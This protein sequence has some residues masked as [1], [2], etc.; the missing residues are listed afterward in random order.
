MSR[1]DLRRHVPRWTG[2]GFG[3]LPSAVAAVVLI[4]LSWTAAVTGQQPSI[5]VEADAAVDRARS[6]RDPAELEAARAD[7]LELSRRYP[8]D[9]YPRF[10]GRSRALVEAASIGRRLGVGNTAAGELLQVLEREPASQWTARAHLE[11][12]DLVLTNGDWQLAADH[13]WHARQGALREAAGSAQESGAVDVPRLALERMTRIDRL[14]LR[15]LAGKN[16][17][18]RMRAYL[19]DD[20]LPEKQKLKRPRSVAAGPRGELLVADD[21]RVVQFDPER[22]LVASR[23]LRGLGQARPTFGPVGPLG[24]ITA[25][26]PAASTVQ[27]LDDPSPIRFERPSGGRLGEIVTAFR[28]PYGNWTVLSRQVDVVLRYDSQGRP[29]EFGQTRLAQPVD[30]APGP[31]GRTYVLDAGQGDARAALLTLDPDGELENTFSADWRRPLALD[32]DAFGNAY[33]LEGRVKQVLV[34]DPDGNM[35]TA[36]GPVLPGGIELRAPNDVA[37]DGMGRVFIAAGRLETVVALE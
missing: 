18:T 15:R 23:E 8:R 12:A 5:D 1:L 35:M 16:P 27:R 2:H 36:L 33:I 10:S 9:L 17:W 14:V 30:M 20:Y 26:V 7:L 21:R 6:A 37:V 31:N 28:G 4:S 22:N 29:L 34:Y 32:V 3:L 13:Y 19:P 24:G 11:L 25:V